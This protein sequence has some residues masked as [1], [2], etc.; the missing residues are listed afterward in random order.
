[1]KWEYLKYNIRKCT[2]KFS[3]KLAKNTNKKIVDL[4]T[5]LRHFEKHYENDVDNMDYKVFRRQLDAVHKEKAKDIKIRTK[6]KCYELGQK[7]TKF[8][9]NLE[10][11]E[12][13][14]SQI[15]S[16]IINQD[17]ITDQNEI[18]KKIFSFYQSLFSRK[19]A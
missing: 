13:I 8:F 1:M 7:S 6:C 19:V 9:L 11:H 10:K 16:V 3:K 17:E 15:H 4:E 2:I 12:A 18:N 14:Q 5:K